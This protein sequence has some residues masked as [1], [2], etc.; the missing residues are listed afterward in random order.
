MLMGEVCWQPFSCVVR[1]AWSMWL[2]GIDTLPDWIDIDPVW[3]SF[4]KNK[5]R[6]FCVTVICNNNP[7]MCSENNVLKSL[8]DLSDDLELNTL[9]PQRFNDWSVENSHQNKSAVVS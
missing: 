6:L 9:K 3:L 1:Q 2:E 8:I 4:G 5:A 7:S